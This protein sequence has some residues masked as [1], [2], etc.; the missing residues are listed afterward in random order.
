[1]A[2][3]E[4]EFGL[5]R[6]IGPAITAFQSQR[7]TTIEAETGALRVLRIAVGTVHSGFSFSCAGKN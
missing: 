6:Q 1:M 2:A 5:G 4:A 7:C 3:I